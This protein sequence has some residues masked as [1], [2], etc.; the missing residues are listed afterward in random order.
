MSSTILSFQPCNAQCRKVVFCKIKP[1][2][3]LVKGGGWVQLELYEFE[4]EQRS[5][6]P[7]SG[8]ASWCFVASSWSA[9]KGDIRCS[10]ISSLTSRLPPTTCLSASMV[11]QGLICSQLGVTAIFLNN[12]CGGQHFAQLAPFRMWPGY[13]PNLSWACEVKACK[14]GNDVCGWRQKWGWNV[15]RQR[16]QTRLR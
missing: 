15:P 2:L 1:T 10:Y 8:E 5:A 3:N 4:K 16:V 13:T 6:W 11:A 7:P 9:G 12:M 14:W